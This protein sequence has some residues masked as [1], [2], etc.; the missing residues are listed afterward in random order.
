MAPMKLE[1]VTAERLVYSEDVD[2]LVAPGIEGE[3]GILPRHAPLLTVLQP[4]EIRVSKDGKETYMTVS[5][6]FIEVM[7]NTVTILADTA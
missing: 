5:G 1:I 2:V 3:L 6:G 4:G 7:S